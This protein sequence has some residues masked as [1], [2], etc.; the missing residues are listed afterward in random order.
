MTVPEAK[1]QIIDLTTALLDAE[2]AASE[3]LG[4][5]DL[6][7]GEDYYAF[8][9]KRYTTILGQTPD[10]IHEIGLAE[11]ARIRAEMMDII[12]SVEFDGDFD[13]FVEF[14]RTDPQF[15]AATPE[16]LLKEAAWIAKRVD[17]AMP[18]FFGLLPRQ[19]Y[20]IVPVPDEIA[21]VRIASG[22]RRPSSM[23]LTTS[24]A[25]LGKTSSSQFDA[26]GDPRWRL[27]FE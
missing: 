13:E 5:E 21:P 25:R 24:C 1:R 18:G 16:E 11:V 22:A 27:N 4:A 15:Y 9:I 12:E 8:Q 19:P 7:G 23:K 2:Y 3:T 20:G 26:E 14:L 10:E 6:E 17:Y